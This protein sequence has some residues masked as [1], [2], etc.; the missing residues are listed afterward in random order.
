LDINDVDDYKY[1]ALMHCCVRGYCGVETRVC[2][3][4]NLGRAACVKILLE[5]G[6]N[7]DFQSLDGSMTPLHWAAYHDDLETVKL[8]VNCKAK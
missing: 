5:M 3:E 8:L 1:T 2:T 7:V 4:A 6:S